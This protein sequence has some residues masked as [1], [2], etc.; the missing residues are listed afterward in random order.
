MAQMACNERAHV[1]T[2]I[3]C[4]FVVFSV[5]IMGFR[6]RDKML[7]LYSSPVHVFFQFSYLFPSLTVTIGSQLVRQI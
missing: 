6:L 5:S 7:P 1:V 2:T 3:F 4:L